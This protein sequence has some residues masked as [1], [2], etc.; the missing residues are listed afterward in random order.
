MGKR[1]RRCVL[2]AAAGAVALVAA[3][4]VPTPPTPG[5]DYQFS[6]GYN[7][8][9]GSWESCAAT[10]GPKFFPAENTD[11]PWSW[12]S[13]TETVDGVNEAVVRFSDGVG[14]QLTTTNETSNDTYSIVMLLRLSDLDGFRRVLQFKDFKTVDNGLYLY[15]GSLMFW[16][17]TAAQSPVGT[18]I[19]SADEWVQVTVTRTST[20]VVRG[21]M[22]GVQQWQFTDTAG[23]AV[24][25]GVTILGYGV[26][27][28]VDNVRNGSEMSPGALARVRVFNRAL[29]DSEIAALGQTPATPCA[30]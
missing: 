18:R 6:A 21:F 25:G 19:A 13:A 9:I 8:T 14:Y 16:R 30:V 24:I 7:P 20:G 22:D 10:P 2:L 29:S 23:D 1:T 11:A 12:T 17:Q 15:R 27:L 4:C 3:A 5:A 28:F 26:Y